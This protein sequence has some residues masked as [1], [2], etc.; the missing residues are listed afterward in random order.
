[1]LAY[2]STPPALFAQIARFL[3]IVESV[4]EGAKTQTKNKEIARR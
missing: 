1:M 2:R 3:M 4:G